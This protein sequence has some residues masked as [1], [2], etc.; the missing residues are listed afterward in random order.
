MIYFYLH[1]SSEL[2]DLPDPSSGCNT[3]KYIEYNTNI[4]P[5]YKINRANT[6]TK[7]EMIKMGY[8]NVP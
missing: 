5:I 3:L 1:Q 2:S 7:L 4:K 6:L 8:R